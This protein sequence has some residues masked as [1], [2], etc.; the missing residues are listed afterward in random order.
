VLP[1][2]NARFYR[3]GRF[4]LLHTFAAA[5]LCATSLAVA[6]GMHVSV[7][8]AQ[9]AGEYSAFRLL[10][11]DKKAT[12]N[13]SDQDYRELDSA[14][15]RLFFDLYNKNYRG[16]NTAATKNFLN[17]VS[18]S[19]DAVVTDPA[20]DLSSTCQAV[21]NE[22]KSFHPNAPNPKVGPCLCR[23]PPPQL[24]LTELKMAEGGGLKVSIDKGKAKSG[25][26]AGFRVL[27]SE[28]DTIG[29]G[30]QEVWSGQAAI[31]SDAAS[32]YAIVARGINLAPDSSHPFLLVDTTPNPSQAPA[33]CEQPL[34]EWL[35]RQKE[36]EPNGLHGPYGSLIDLIK[37]DSAGLIALQRTGLSS[38]STG[39]SE[40]GFVIVRDQRQSTG[41][42][43]AAPPVASSQPFSFLNPPLIAPQDYQ[44]SLD[45]AFKNSCENESNFLPKPPTV[46]ATVHT[47]P[48]LSGL[49]AHNFSAPDFRGAIIQK[50]LHPEFEGIFMI[51]WLDRKA[52]MFIPTAADC[53]GATAAT[54]GDPKANLDYCLFSQDDL[55]LAKKDPTDVP[56]WNKYVK[57]V[58]EVCTFPSDGP[59]R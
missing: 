37:Q 7:T 46:T 25:V 24:M 23:E 12:C 38:Q 41:G 10:V 28:T 56:L 1:R 54:V 42:Y 52:R 43:Y 22:V 45:M 35:P 3:A 33:S 20:Y 17:A 55:E 49:V 29:Q 36:P 4:A 5:E 13:I 40:W 34:R 2:R 9:A 27:R 53:P 16:P 48:L 14:A 11:R 8:D 15:D 44:K 21:L 51:D 47:H 50:L 58:E 59:C 32:D 19:K 26:S 31:E 18:Q 39:L 30:A 57:R 6:Q